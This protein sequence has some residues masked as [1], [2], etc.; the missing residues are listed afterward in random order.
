MGTSLVDSFYA[1]CSAHPWLGEFG[2]LLAGMGV[3]PVLFLVG[4]VGGFT[5]CAGMCGPFVL[6][7]VAGNERYLCRPGMGEGRRLRAA[8]LLPYHLGRFTTYAL[9]GALM[10]GIAGFTVWLSGFHWLPALLLGGAAALF[11]AQGLAGLP[12]LLGLRGFAPANP[13]AAPLVR[14]ARPLLD[15]P[16]GMRGYA[17]GAALGFLPCGMLYGALTAAA[18][19]GGALQGALAMMAF[20]AGTVPSLGLVGYVGVFFG[21]RA[22]GATRAL[23]VPLMLLN[24]ALLAFFAFRDLG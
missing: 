10:G 1:L 20:V 17:L 13:L 16:R 8:L 21:R 22:P 12:R 23:G 24:S 3:A 7:Q 18:G 9:L 5:H 14:L 6:A 15:N 2:R 19:A 4:L 11:L